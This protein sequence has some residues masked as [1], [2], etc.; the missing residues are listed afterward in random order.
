MVGLSAAAK[1]PIPNKVRIGAKVGKVG[2]TVVLLNLVAHSVSS[3]Q[4]VRLSPKRVNRI[5]LICPKL[6]FGLHTSEL[7]GGN[8]VAQAI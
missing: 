4:S 7:V 5:A 3:A 1:E 2:N 6:E 8:T